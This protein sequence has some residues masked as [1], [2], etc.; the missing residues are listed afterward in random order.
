M[1]Y[2]DQEWHAQIRRAADALILAI[3][4]NNKAPLIVRWSAE[5]HVKLALELLEPPVP[6]K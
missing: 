1:T 5:G 3:Q 4:S 6:T 2:D